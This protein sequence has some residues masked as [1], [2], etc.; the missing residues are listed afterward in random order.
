MK[1]FELNFDKTI[2]AGEV[3]LEYT[4]Q[5]L[6]ELSE[7]IDDLAAQTILTTAKTVNDLKK[8]TT[9][10]FGVKTAIAGLGLSALGDAAGIDSL[11]TIGETLTEAGGTIAGITAIGT[12]YKNRNV[13]IEE[14]QAL[15]DTQHVEETTVIELD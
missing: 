12:L 10:K 6:G 3:A 7:V 8:S 5:E 2:N 15:I 13:S 1:E 9:F 11:S 4:K 14:C